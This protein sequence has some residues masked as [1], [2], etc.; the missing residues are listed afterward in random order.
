[1]NKIKRSKYIKSLGVFQDENLTWKGHIKYTENKTAKNIDLLFI[2][3]PYLTKK[4]LLSLYYSYIHT[5]IS[6]PNIWG[7]AYI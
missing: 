7:S 3:K 2:S 5:Y 4:C 6:Y 1:M